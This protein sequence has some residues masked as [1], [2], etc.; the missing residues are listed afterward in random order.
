MIKVIK[1][2]QNLLETLQELLWII[3]PL[4]LL[5]ISLILIALRDWYK[6]REMLEQNKL[7]W[8]L[9]ILFF[10]LF[11]PVIYLWY[12]HT[13]VMTVDDSEDEWGN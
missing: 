1:V 12:S 13:K 7:I 10:N 3:I 2:E 8:L 4:V 5:E 6:K 11:G 9:V